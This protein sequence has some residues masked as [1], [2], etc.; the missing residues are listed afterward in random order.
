MLTRREDTVRKTRNLH[1]W[2]GLFTSLLILIEAVTGLLLVE[3]ALMG[4]LRGE[5]RVMINKPTT[6]QVPE[7]PA[8]GQQQAGQQAT[9]DQSNSGQVPGRRGPDKLVMEEDGK[10]NP[11]GQGSSFASFVKGLHSGR[12]GGTDISIVLDLVAISLI[13]MTVTG[14]ILTVKAL[15]RRRA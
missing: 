6:G 11:A 2:I 1:L 14:M 3:P 8:A 9:A 4:Q 10:L 5:Q 7:V 15:K 13:F 12:I